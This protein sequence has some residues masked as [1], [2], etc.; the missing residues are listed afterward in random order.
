MMQG[1]IVLNK[2][3]GITSHKACKKVQSLTGA[4]KAGHA[5]S[6]DPEAEGVLLVCLNEATRISEYLTELDKEYIATG[7]LGI[8]TDSHDLTGKVIEENDSSN[9]NFE[10]LL[11]VLNN[12]KGEIIQTPPPYSAIRKDGQRLYKLARKGVLVEPPPR[13]VK[14]HELEVISFNPPEFTLRVRCSKGTYV[15]TLIHDIG[16]ALGP[17]AALKALQRTSIGHFSIDRAC[18]FEDIQEGRCKYLNID[19]A[20]AHIPALR[21]SPFQFRLA[22]YGTGFKSKTTYPP[23][24]LL[25]LQEPSLGQ[26]FGIGK[27]KSDGSI[28]VEKVLIK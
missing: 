7:V 10:Q 3:A 18:S 12:F 6:L 16:K 24:T 2:P 23:G 28:K 8:I 1:V 19:E 21:L 9:V 14:I 13:S 5:G 27:V 15:R 25:R 11:A 26:C 20:L 22:R 17:G 4:Y